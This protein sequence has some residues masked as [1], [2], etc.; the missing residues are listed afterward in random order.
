MLA[1]MWGKG[2]PNCWWE[3]SQ[4]QPQWKTAWSILKKLKM[5]VPF[6]LEIP[7]LGIYPNDPETPTQE[8]ICT[9]MF[10][11]ALSPNSQNLETAYVPI[12][13]RVVEK[14]MVH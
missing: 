2:N 3:C 12:S 9:S 8:N 5:E 11:A 1:K 6:D 10:T 14:A 7:L 4:V 13:R